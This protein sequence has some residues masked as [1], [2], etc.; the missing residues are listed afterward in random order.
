MDIY[1]NVYFF[2]MCT[3]LLTL[4]LVTI[5]L[6]LAILTYEGSDG[7]TGWYAFWSQENIV[8]NIFIVVLTSL[9]TS[10]SILNTV[11]TT[12]K[13]K[14]KTKLLEEIHQL[15]VLDKNRSL[16]VEKIKD[17]KRLYEIRKNMPLTGIYSAKYNDGTLKGTLHMP[18]G[19]SK[20]TRDLDRY[21]SD[22]VE[23]R[24]IMYD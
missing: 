3:F 15:I 22:D 18:Q 11:K 7:N 5:F 12:F 16:W 8:F 10:A 23:M 24:S 14:K 20:G 19:I 1:S 6:L 4:L 17:Y 21:S 9:L 13:N 2:W